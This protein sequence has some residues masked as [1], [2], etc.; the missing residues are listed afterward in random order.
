MFLQWINFA[1]ADTIL[2]KTKRKKNDKDK[3]F[4]ALNTNYENRMIELEKPISKI[5]NFNSELKKRKEEK[6]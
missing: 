3:E 5:G 2:K 4:R 1:S 6:S